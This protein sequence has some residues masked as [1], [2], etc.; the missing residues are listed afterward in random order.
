M[1]TSFYTISPHFLTPGTV[2]KPDSIETDGVVQHPVKNSG[3]KSKVSELYEFCQAFHLGQPEPID[4]TPPNRSSPSTHYAAYKIDDEQFGIGSGKTKK[5]A[6][7]VAAKLTLEE[8]IQRNEGS[9]YTPVGTTEGDEI[10]AM[11]WNCL[12]KISKCA[13]DSW[14]FAGYKVLATVIMKDTGADSSCVVSLGTGN[15]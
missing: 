6:R 7:E 9:K 15:K 8:L 12:S 3:T 4:V 10:A 2:D 1:L 5:A 14:R 11:S 13:P